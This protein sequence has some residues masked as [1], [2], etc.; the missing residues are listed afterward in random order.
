MDGQ[1]VLFPFGKDRSRLHRGGCHPRMVDEAGETDL[2]FERIELG[3][4]AT[5]PVV[6]N[7]RSLIVMEGSSIHRLVDVTDDR[8]WVVVDEHHVRPV[9]GGSSAVGDYRG[10]RVTRHEDLALDQREATG[11]VLGRVWCRRH[12]HVRHLI[13]GDHQLDALDLH[14]GL[15]IDR[16]DGGVSERTA[17]HCQVERARRAYVINVTS[18]PSDER[19]VLAPLY[20]RANKRR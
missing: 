1:P 20:G 13:G 6:G 16:S 18:G 14:G 5:G 19:R 7:V 9:A 3:A 2:T 10:N 12:L 8:E 4:V 15:D 17:D 11:N